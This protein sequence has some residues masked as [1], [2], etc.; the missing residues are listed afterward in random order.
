M[1]AGKPPP[2]FI[3]NC[4]TPPCPF[5]QS[6]TTASRTPCSKPDSKPSSTRPGPTS[7]AP[8][9]TRPTPPRRTEPANQSRPQPD[10]P[11]PPSL[12]P[13]STRYCVPALCI[14]ASTHQQMHAPGGTRSA[15]SLRK[16]IHHADS[17]LEHRI[18][19]AKTSVHNLGFL[20]F[21]CLLVQTK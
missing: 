14:G 8:T 21:L 17:L 18:P 19:S 20:R 10:P 16:L 13:L 15:Y 3:P 11:P 7:S 1:P 5:S 12:S 9:T 4:L 6:A 2:G